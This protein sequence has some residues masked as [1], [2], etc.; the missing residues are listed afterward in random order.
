MRV[1]TVTTTRTIIENSM[2]VSSAPWRTDRSQPNN[3]GSAIRLPS[4]GVIDGLLNTKLWIASAAA[5]V[6]TASWAPRMRRAGTPTTTPSAVA[7]SAE[8]RM[9]SGNGTPQFVVTFDRANPAEPAKA[10]LASEI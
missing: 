1:S 7:I 6:T 2:V 4:N 9:L 10:I 8:S 5:S 3:F